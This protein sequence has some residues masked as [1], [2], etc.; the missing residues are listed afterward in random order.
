MDFF[1]ATT[2]NPSTKATPP[3]AADRH[4]TLSQ[5]WPLLAL[6][7]L[8][9]LSVVAFAL[10]QP[11]KVL[12]RLRPAPAF[13]VTDQAGR[14]LTNENLRGQ[15][16]LYT[17]SPARC[18][19]ACEPTDAIMQTIQAQVARLSAGGLP[20]RLV[21]ILF[22]SQ[23]VAAETMQAFA[24]AH[25]A[26][27]M[28][29]WVVSGDPAALKQ[30]IGAGFEVYYAAGPDGEYAFEPAI[31]LVDG[32]GMIRGDYRRQTQNLDAATILRHIEV[33]QNEVRNDSGLSRLAYE[34]AHFFLCYAH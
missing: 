33:L 3:V 10:L 14:R 30:T 13:S 5:R 34:A 8:L 25:G 9:A 26:D 6:P 19:A 22:D 2:R 4:P 28:R 31:V 21:T 32:L 17:F 1:S 24:L 18:P 11:L 12:P 29:W 16:V 23:P 7:L 27:P 20:L 15:L